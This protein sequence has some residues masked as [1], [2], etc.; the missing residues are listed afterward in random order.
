MNLGKVGVI[1]AARTGS[2]RLPGKALLP[3]GGMPMALFLLR[4]LMP[5]RGAQLV[6]ATTTLAGDDV[7]A[8]IVADAGVPVFRG[9]PA[10]LV[11]RYCDAAAQFGFDTVVRITADCPF[12]DAAL[13]EHCLQQAQEIGQWDIAT[14]KGQFPVGLDAEIYPARLMQRLNEAAPLSAEDREH[15]TLH[16]YR[17]DYAVVRLVPSADWLASSGV[18]TVDTPQD[19]ELAA[20]IVA[21]F[22]GADFSIKELLSR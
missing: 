10:D 19:Y 22:N 3:L 9:D 6:L 17:N 15:L 12:V 1:V 7:L 14:T 11:Q 2:S 5:V 20:Q 18:F 16:L 21:A 8:Q 13:V 4:R